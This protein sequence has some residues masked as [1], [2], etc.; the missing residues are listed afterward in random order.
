MHK[1]GIFVPKSIFLKFWL[2]CHKLVSR[3]FKLKF[4]K[5]YFY[6]KLI[7][8]SYNTSKK[9]APRSDSKVIIVSLIPSM[10]KELSKST[11]EKRK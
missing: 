5:I 2:E 7:D 8:I 10:N 3:I 9:H 4:I 11:N 1:W 6:E